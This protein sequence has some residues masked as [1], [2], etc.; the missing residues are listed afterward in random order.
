MSCPAN[1]HDFLVIWLRA[2]GQ[3]VKSCGCE[4][5]ECGEQ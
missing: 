3:S 1:L 5:A 4:P 2:A